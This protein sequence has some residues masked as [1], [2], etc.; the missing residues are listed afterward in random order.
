MIA[1]QY[2]RQSSRARPSA[3]PP[4]VDTPTA[5]RRKLGPLTSVPLRPRVLVIAEAANPEWI[6]VPLVGWSLA[7]ALRRVAD[8]HVVT[9]QRNRAA[10]ERAGWVSGSDFTPLDNEAMAGPIWRLADRLR[11]RSGVGW[12]LVTALSVP[13]Y[14]RFEHLL[15]RRFERDLRAGAWDLVH[16]VTPLSPT[17]PSL[18]AGR[19]R[20][21]GVPFVV[22]PLNGGVPWPREFAGARRREHEWLSY[23]RDGYRWL[24]GYRA[25]R[26]AAAAILVGSRA[27]WQSRGIF[28]NRSLAPNPW[29]V[30][31]RTFW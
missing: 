6:S 25:M 27:T 17:T 2:S 15:W 9:Q 29:P 8:V 24:P 14:Y 10:I 31:S 22:G 13:A 11:G 1:P 7:K 4:S 16:R 18:L 21:I 12:T 3:T 28:R 26:D 30:R 5:G 20:A 23:M 19:L